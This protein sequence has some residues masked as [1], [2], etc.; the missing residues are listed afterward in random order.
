MGKKNKKSRRYDDDDLLGGP[1]IIEAPIRSVPK[2]V[3][4]V[5]FKEGLQKIGDN[6]FHNCSSL[7]SITIPSTV[8]EIGVVHLIV[9]SI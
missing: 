3:I 2:D 1:L 5:R 9:A 8:T 6:A 4:S 7:K